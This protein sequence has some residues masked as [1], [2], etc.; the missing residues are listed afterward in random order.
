M[1][2]GTDEITRKRID[3]GQVPDYGL[4]LSINGYRLG[5]TGKCRWRIEPEAWTSNID[6]EDSGYIA[7]ILEKVVKVLRHEVD[8]A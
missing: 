7:D 3:T 6:P 2:T 8:E 5:D 1:T 4:V